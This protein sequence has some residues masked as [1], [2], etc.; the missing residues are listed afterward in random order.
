MGFVHEFGFYFIEVAGDF[1]SEIELFCDDFSVFSKGILRIE[2]FRVAF[3]S[4]DYMHEVIY[5][6]KSY[7]YSYLL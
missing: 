5:H 2:I 3:F 7:K 1:F 4:L 6:Y